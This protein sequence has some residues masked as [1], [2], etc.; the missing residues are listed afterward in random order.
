MTNRWV[1]MLTSAVLLTSALPASA[2]A[3]SPP[4]TPS[5]ETSADDLRQADATGKSPVLRFAAAAEK[6]QLALPS[7]K[8]KPAGRSV[9]QP[10]SSRWLEP[11]AAAQPKGGLPDELGPPDLLSP[12][13]GP[14]ALRPEPMAEEL[15]VG[16]LAGTLLDSDPLHSAP[17][18]DFGPSPRVPLHQQPMMR[19]SWMFRPWNISLFEGGLFAATPAQAQF[20]T[21]ASY[22]TGFR[23]GWDYSTHFGGETRFGFS[24]VYMVDAATRSVEVGYQKLFYFDSNL[25]IYPWG[26]TRWRPF[27]SIGGGL[28][29]IN[30]VS[31]NGP[32]LHPGAFNLPWGGGIK[33]RVGTR[34]AFRADVRDNLTFSGSGGLRTENNIE[35]LGGIE[36]HFGGGERRSYWPW[37]PSRHWW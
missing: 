16:P 18:P 11:G 23:V 5:G 19:E 4:A 31:N 27:L 13:T 7:L 35:V 22:F 15:P 21:T 10:S 28:A 14:G 36:F 25:L 37:N 32:V 20:K 12:E 3:Q 33:Y 6:A 9:L 30:I 29:D 8:P 24:K 34:I 1:V 17:L 26:D 2:W